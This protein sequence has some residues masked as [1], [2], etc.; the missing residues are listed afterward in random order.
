MLKIGT[1]LRPLQPAPAAA[2]SGAARR[3]AAPPGARRHAPTH[4]RGRRARG[5]AQD[6]FLVGFLE[7]E[8]DTLRAVATALNAA[9]G[10]VQAAQ[11]APRAPAARHASDLG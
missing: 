7:G 3:R 4:V 10:A 9:G 6:V 8:V 11:T 2:A 1:A 5:R